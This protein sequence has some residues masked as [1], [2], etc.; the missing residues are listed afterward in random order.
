MQTEKILRSV[1]GCCKLGAYHKHSNFFWS[2]LGAVGTAN[3]KKIRP[4]NAPNAVSAKDS[5]RIR[6]IRRSKI[7]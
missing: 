4:P 5:K 1:L 7:F 3:L 2:A 6:P